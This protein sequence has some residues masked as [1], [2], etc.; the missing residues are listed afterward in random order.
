MARGVSPTLP[1]R[2][3]VPNALARAFTEH[4]SGRSR[5]DGDDALGSGGRS[6]APPPIGRSAA[7]T[8]LPRDRELSEARPRPQRFQVL[9]DSPSA[10]FS[11]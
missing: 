4:L 5:S 3:S 2:A 7:G 10:I 8:A 11:P 9:R 6:A 1:R